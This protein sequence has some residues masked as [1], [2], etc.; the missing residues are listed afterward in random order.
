MFKWA[1]SDKFPRFQFKLPFS[2][3]LILAGYG[4]RFFSASNW[5]VSYFYAFGLLYVVCKVYLFLEDIWSV[6]YQVVFS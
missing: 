2:I 5:L 3:A 6:I 1:L 4:C